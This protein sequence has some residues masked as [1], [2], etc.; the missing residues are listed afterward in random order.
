MSVRRTFLSIALAWNTVISTAV[1]AAPEAAALARRIDALLAEGHQ[2]QAE[3]AP[4]AD[5][6]T[7]LRR[8]YLD[9][10]GRI[11][12]V[13]EV[14][15]FLEAQSTDKRAV[16]TEEL[17][18][19]SA[20]AR[21]FATFWRRTWIPQ[22]DTPQFVG[23]SAEVEPWLAAR[24]RENSPYDH[25]VHALLTVPASGKPEAGKAQDRQAAPRAFFA[26]SEYKPENLAANTARA[27][28]GVNL[29]CAQCHDHPFSRWTRE[30]FWQTAAFF[31]R[32]TR[33]TEA[34][35]VRLELAIANTDQVVTP[36]LLVSAQPAWPENIEPDTGRH[37]LADWIC[38]KQNPYLARNGVNR[39][40][41]YFFGAGL[42]EPLD[43][44]SG[45]NPASH[46]RLLD[47]LAASFADSGFDL[48]F[49][50]SAYMSTRIYQSTSRPQASAVSGPGTSGSVDPRAFAYMPIRALTGEQLY[51]SLRVAAALPVEREDLD[52]ASVTAARR[53]FTAG[54][55]V[56]RPVA[57]QRSIMQA[58]ALMNGELTTEVTDFATSPLLRATVNSPFLGTPERVQTL[59][60][61][62]LGRLPADDELVALVAHASRHSDEG[63]A[64]RALADIFWA[65][66]NSSEFNTNR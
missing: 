27:F 13:A 34:L 63:A 10:V 60:L 43:D 15:T 4:L 33:A 56:D 65:L 39:L 17:L 28:L 30:Q 29:D 50:A 62:T 51:A 52:S 7:F 38:D 64:G 54:F 37:L 55:R 35:P 24:L 23:L 18:A 1:A 22:A 3:L 44:L 49:L 46:P 16:L 9:A 14:R 8:L 11:P 6:A 47:E 58:L 25:I 2:K 40:W 45:E 53:R 12:T 57:A 20:S 66:I 21:H 26:A 61:A 36:R 48:R 42:I 5:D 32:P 31:A 19:S 59:F 41:A